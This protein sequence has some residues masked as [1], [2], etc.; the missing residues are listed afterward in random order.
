MNEQQKKVFELDDLIP[1][2][3]L[4]LIGMIEHP[5][6]SQSAIARKMKINVPHASNVAASIES[7]GYIIRHKQEKWQQARIE[8][9]V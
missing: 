3:K 8:I 7:K 2:E 6:L 1:S 4:F 5:E 9:L